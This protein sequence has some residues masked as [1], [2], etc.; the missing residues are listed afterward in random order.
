MQCGRIQFPIPVRGSDIIVFSELTTR[1]A[2]NGKGGRGESVTFG[3]WK[4]SRSL[5]FVSSKQ[6]DE[7]LFYFYFFSH[8]VLLTECFNNTIYVQ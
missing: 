5:E 6:K 3:S 8:T 4:Y 1:V 2:I 7:I